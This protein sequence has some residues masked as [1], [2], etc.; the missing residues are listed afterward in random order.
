MRNFE[1]TKVVSETS[2]LTRLKFVATDS[3]QHITA[4][5]YF[6]CLYQLS[7]V[8]LEV[9]DVFADNCVKMKLNL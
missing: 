4:Q 2:D 5:S 7:P 3:L 8:M 1:F 9:F 6:S